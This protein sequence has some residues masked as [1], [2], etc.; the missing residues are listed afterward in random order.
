MD[1][2]TDVIIRLMTERF[3]IPADVQPDATFAELA[4]DSLALLA[5]ALAVEEELGLIIEQDELTTDHTVTTTAEL[6]ASKAEG[7]VA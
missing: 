3:G 6:L 7:L 1:T 2:Y 5:L 4:F